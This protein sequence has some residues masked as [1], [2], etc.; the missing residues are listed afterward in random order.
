M[1]DRPLTRTEQRETLARLEALGADVKRLREQH[2]D[3]DLD[4]VAFT[5][6]GLVGHLQAA[7]AAAPA[8]E[9]PTNG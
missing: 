9:D 5:L 2:P 1:A 4:G 8:V 7:V 6:A 3:S